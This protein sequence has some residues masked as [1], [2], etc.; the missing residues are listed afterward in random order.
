[1]NKNDF[2]KNTEQSVTI[3]NIVQ[4]KE[5]LALKLRLQREKINRS[6]RKLLTP[7]TQNT[8]FISSFFGNALQSFAF[9]DSILTGWNIIKKVTSLFKRKR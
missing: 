4:K 9:F 6:Y 2:V 7:E 5:E 3:E 8:G 1:M